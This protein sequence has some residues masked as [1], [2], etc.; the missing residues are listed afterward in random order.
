MNEPRYA[1]LP[2]IMK[3]KKKPLT[4]VTVEDLNLGDL[5]L[6][7]QELGKEGA[8]VKTVQM[9]VP[10]IERK[11]TII[12]GSDEPMVKGEEVERSAEELIKLLRE[13]AKVI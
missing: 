6:S 3:A 2:G 8:R 7:E 9:K 5:G 11:L 12:K 1:S 10:Q 4:V 13:E